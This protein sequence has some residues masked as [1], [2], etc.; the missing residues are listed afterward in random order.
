MSD[1]TFVVGGES[2]ANDVLGAPEG[3]YVNTDYVTQGPAPRSVNF[4]IDR[5]ADRL[6]GT[7]IFFRKQNFNIRL[8]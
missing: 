7:T 8:L 2:D 6:R 1:G 5:G 3:R 4:H